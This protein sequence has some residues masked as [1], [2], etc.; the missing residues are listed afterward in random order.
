[1]YAIYDIRETYALSKLRIARCNITHCYIIHHI[2]YA[3]KSGRYITLQGEQ[4]DI[5]LLLST[6]GITQTYLLLCYLDY[7]YWFSFQRVWVITWQNLTKINTLFYITRECYRSPEFKV[8]SNTT[9]LMS[10]LAWTNVPLKH[11]S[12]YA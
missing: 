11:S 3:S 9:F 1:V 6:Q 5:Q 8:A 7:D 12:R 4:N 2:Q 10:P